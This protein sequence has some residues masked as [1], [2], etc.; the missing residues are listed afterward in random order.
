MEASCSGRTLA[1]PSQRTPLRPCG[2]WDAVPRPCCSRGWRLA[3]AQLRLTAPRSLHRRRQLRPAAALPAAELAEA[4]AAAQLWAASAHAAAPPHAAALL[5]DAAPGLDHLLQQ[6]LH[7]ADAA[8]AAL[9]A[10]GDATAAGAAA[11]TAAGKAQ[12]NGWLTPLVEAL[13]TVLKY[14]QVRRRYTRQA[15]HGFS[16]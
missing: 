4:A 1:A 3:T 8:A 6:L 16:E 10:P 11:G 7:L 13:E 9:P 2:R 5:Q 14:F 15:V 12:D